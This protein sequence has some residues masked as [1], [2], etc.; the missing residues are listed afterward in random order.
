[1]KKMN[2]TERENISKVF[3]SAVVTRTMGK[4]NAIIVIHTRWH[5]D[6]LIG[7][8][9]KKQ[10]FIYVNIPC[11]WEKG[12]DKL[13]HRKVGEVLCPEL[14]HTVEWAMNKKNNVGSRVWNALYQGKPFIEGGNIV[15][16][17]DLKWY[18]KKTAILTDSGFF[19]YLQLVT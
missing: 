14:G 16:R 11:V 12:I 4:G 5:E 8:L 13:L 17:K 7:R 19:V 6:D 2:K 9:M 1:M 10:G 18:N 15:Q 3:K